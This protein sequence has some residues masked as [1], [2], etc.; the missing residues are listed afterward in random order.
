MY[1]MSED[2][3]L[4]GSEL[5]E[6]LKK[7]EKYGLDMLLAI[8]DRESSITYYLVKKIELPKSKYEYYEIEWLQP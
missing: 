2:E 6:V 3:Y 7:C 8:S 4:G 1:S 5:A